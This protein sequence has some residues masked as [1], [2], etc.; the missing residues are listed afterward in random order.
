MVLWKCWGKPHS[1]LQIRDERCMAKI[2]AL[3]PPIPHGSWTRSSCKTWKSYLLMM[4]RCAKVKECAWFL[5]GDA[6]GIPTLKTWKMIAGVMWIIS[7]Y[8]GK[9]YNDPGVWGRNPWAWI[10][11]QP[12]VKSQN[13]ASKKQQWSQVTWR[14]G[15]VNHP[16]WPP[17]IPKPVPNKHNNI[18]LWHR[19]LLLSYTYLKNK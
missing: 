4:C 18:I 15:N 16:L 19:K 1:Q 12:A 5:E 13:H 11:R 6:N 7:V 10:F 9:L 8:K 14:E 3:L 2:S 17:S